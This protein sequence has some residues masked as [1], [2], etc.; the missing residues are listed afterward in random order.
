MAWLGS[1][2]ALSPTTRTFMEARFGRDFSNIRVHTDARASSSAQS[3]SA[4][5]YTVGRNI[6]FKSGQYQPDTHAGRRLLAHELAH[7]LQAG[8]AMRLAR[9]PDETEEEIKRRAATDIAKAADSAN[10]GAQAQAN[11]APPAAASAPTTAATAAAAPGAK[12]PANDATAAPSTTPAEDGVTLSVSGIRQTV[13]GHTPAPPS[14]AAYPDAP[15]RKT[16]I[17]EYNPAPAKRL[18]EKETATLPPLDFSHFR[19]DAELAQFAKQLALARAKRDVAGVV[20]SRYEKALNTALSQAQNENK[21]NAAAALAAA[22]EGINPKDAAALKRAKASAT[23]AASLAAKS[24]TEQARAS[25]QKQDIALVTSELAKEHEDSLELDYKKTLEA[26][27]KSRR[28]GWLSRMQTE[29]NAK[30]NALLKAKSATPKVKKGETPPPAKT[31]DAIEA[32]VEAAMDKLRFD[33]RAN[34]LKQIEAVSFAWAVGRREQYDFATIAVKSAPVGQIIPGYVVALE[35]RVPI[36]A[37]LQR[38]SESEKANMPGVAP[39]LAEFLDNIS[40]IPNTPLFQA[41]NRNN[42]GGGKDAN[43]RAFSNKWFSVDIY[44]RQRS[45]NPGKRD[46]LGTEAAG[47]DQRGFWQVEQAVAFLKSMDQVAVAMNAKWNILYNDFVVAKAVNSQAKNGYVSFTGH[48]DS[49]GNPNWHGPENLLLHFHLDLQI[50]KKQPQRIN[51]VRL[52]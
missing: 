4:L 46:S 25:V 20:Q 28:A 50:A 10:P 35:D 30:R 29:L 12:A 38:G 17:P 37:H 52:D 40:K 44:L 41:D 11:D 43:P 27:V 14:L 9:Q 15:L 7:T 13:G 47:T 8:S 45:D 18:P 42:H 22:I 2:Q 48:L 32:E 34:I 26:V 24:H 51:G 19:N 31:A 23:L 5:A 3:V 33:L 36:P 49:G 16:I 6:I 21:A 1:G 39:E